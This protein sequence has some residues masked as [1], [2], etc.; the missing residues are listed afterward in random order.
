MQMV[1]VMI[2]RTIANDIIYLLSLMS[3]CNAVQVCS[4][5]K[6]TSVCSV[7]LCTWFKVGGGIVTV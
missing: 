6:P 7:V 1:I 4:I 2:E 5:E 3:L